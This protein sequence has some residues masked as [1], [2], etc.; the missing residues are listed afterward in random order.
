MDV[1][2]FAPT[3]I[4][5]LITALPCANVEAMPLP[6]NVA[7]FVLFDPHVTAPEILAGGLLSE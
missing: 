4:V 7:V 6:F 2:R 5:A 1:T 3:R